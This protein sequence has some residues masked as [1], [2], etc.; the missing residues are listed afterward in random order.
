MKNLIFVFGILFSTIVSGQNMVVD[1]PRPVSGGTPVDITLDISQS[2]DDVEEDVPGGSNSDTSSDLEMTYDG[3]EQIVG[4]RYLAAGIP[5]GAT[6]TAA[7]VQ[8]TSRHSD[9]GACTLRVY[10]IL[11]PSPGPINGAGDLNGATWTTNYVDWIP[12]A[13]TSSD[14][15]SAATKTPDFSAVLQEVVD[16]A[17]FTTSSNLVVLIVAQPFDGQVNQRRNARSW[18]NDPAKA[19]DFEITYLN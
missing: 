8:F 7:A 10:M 14:E 6:I 13:W 18:D 9:A 1:A 4:L 15:V 12:A 3:V 2:I 19:A 5:Q 16:Q 17:T 11:D